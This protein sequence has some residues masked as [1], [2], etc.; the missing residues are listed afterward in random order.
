MSWELSPCFKAL[1]S[2]PHTCPKCDAFLNLE[3]LKLTWD[4]AM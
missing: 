3:G 2:T 4:A 1:A